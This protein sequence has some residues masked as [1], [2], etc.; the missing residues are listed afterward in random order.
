M[1]PF[2]TYLLRTG[3][4]T[5]SITMVEL[6]NEMIDNSVSNLRLSFFLYT[7]CLYSYNLHMKCGWL[8]LL[9]RQKK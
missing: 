9:P 7:G 5:C 6:M 8:F 4:S 3:A 1:P 2:S